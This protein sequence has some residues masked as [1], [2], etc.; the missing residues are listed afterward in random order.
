MLK[1]KKDSEHILHFFLASWGPESPRMHCQGLYRPSWCLQSSLDRVCN[2][3][4]LGLGA[5]FYTLSQFK[6]GSYSAG[7][8]QLE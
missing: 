3:P 8:P 5:G 2:I 7:V 1:N 6:E 4:A